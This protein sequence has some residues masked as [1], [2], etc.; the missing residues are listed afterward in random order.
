M[1]KDRRVSTRRLT[2]LALL[3]ALELVMTYT[4]LGLL[5][6]GPINASLLTIPVAIGGMLLGPGAGALLGLIFGLTS[7]LNA[8]Q[9]KSQMGLALFT[10]SPVGYFVVA[11]V[12]RVAMGA[13]AALVFRAVLRLLPKHDKLAAV[14]GG[15]AAPFLNTVFYMGLLM[16]LFYHSDYIQTLA[17]AKGAANVFALIVVMVGVQAVVEW[18]LGCAVSAAVTVPLRKVLRR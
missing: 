13:C 8:V 11:V 10:A 15:F 9:G 4:P 6:V 1:Q 18:G 17:A 7:F 2:E 12:A 3:I 16:A 5:P 14:A